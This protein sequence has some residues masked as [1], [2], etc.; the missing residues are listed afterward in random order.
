MFFLALTRRQMISAILRRNRVSLAEL[1]HRFAMPLKDFVREFEYVRKGLPHDQV[2]RFEHPYCRRCGFVF[3][4][5][6]RV[7]APTKCPKCRSESIEP[8]VYWI[9]PRSR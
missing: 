8:A 5:K 1:A 4:E 2:L 7:K 6:H 3:K 9:E